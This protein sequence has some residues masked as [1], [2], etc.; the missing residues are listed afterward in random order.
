MAIMMSYETTLHSL[1]CKNIFYKN[2]I[3]AENSEILSL[4]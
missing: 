1:F 2:L 4:L 3:K